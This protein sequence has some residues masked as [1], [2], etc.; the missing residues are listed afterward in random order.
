MVTRSSHPDKRFVPG[1]PGDGETSDMG[2]KQR[3]GV[4]VLRGFDGFFGCHVD[5]GPALVILAAIQGHE[6]KPA[7]PSANLGKVRPALLFPGQS[8]PTAFYFAAVIGLNSAVPVTR[9]F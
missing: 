5:I 6:I 7:K 1:V 3:A 9:E 2:R 4:Q 8:L